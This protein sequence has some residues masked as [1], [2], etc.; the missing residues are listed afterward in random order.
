MCPSCIERCRREGE[1][2]EFCRQRVLHDRV[3]FALAA[4]PL[5]VWPLT[6]LTAPAALLY[7]ARHWRAPGSLLPHTRFRLWAAVVLSA[8]QVLL[9]LLA[10]AYWLATSR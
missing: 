10:A 9:W 2:D 4:A 6:I 3:A 5:L 7:A 8:V 1:R